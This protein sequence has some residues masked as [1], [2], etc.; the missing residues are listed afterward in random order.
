[1]RCGSL[2]S[3]PL[4]QSAVIVAEAQ[5]PGARQYEAHIG[6]FNARPEGATR[7]AGRINGGEMARA[8]SLHG[9][10]A[11]HVD[12]EAGLFENLPHNRVARVLSAPHPAPRERSRWRPPVRMAGEKDA[13]IGVINDGDGAGDEMRVRAP[14][15][16]TAC[17]AGQPLPDAYA[18]PLQPSAIQSCPPV[19]CD[20]S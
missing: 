17:P 20:S 9:E 11:E 3:E 12:C 1:M 13:A 19:R 5:R 18:E 2:K 6:H 7:Y 8:F 14:C 15:Q 4:D 10:R 16:R